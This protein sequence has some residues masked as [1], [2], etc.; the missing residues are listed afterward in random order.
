MARRKKWS[1]WETGPETRVGE[2]PLL[3]EQFRHNDNF[4]AWFSSSACECPSEENSDKSEEKNDEK[5]RGHYMY[6]AL[7]HGPPESRRK[8]VSKGTWEAHRH[9]LCWQLVLLL[10]VRWWVRRLLLKRCV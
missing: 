3:E 10:V 5:N 9:S 7:R 1:D 6:A 8:A 4:A 2:R